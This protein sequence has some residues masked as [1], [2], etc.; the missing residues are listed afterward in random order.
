MHAC[1]VHASSQH[2]SCQRPLPAPFALTGMLGCIICA[3]AATACCFATC[4]PGLIKNIQASAVRPV[5]PGRTLSNEPQRSAAATATTF[6]QSST[7]A[8]GPPSFVGSADTHDSERCHDDHGDEDGDANGVIHCCDA[9]LYAHIDQLTDQGRVRVLR[10]PEAVIR[11]GVEMGNC[12]ADIPD[13]AKDFGSLYAKAEDAHGAVLAVGEFRRGKWV[14]I[15][16]NPNRPGRRNRACGRGKAVLS[17][18]EVLKLFQEYEPRL[19]EFE[20]RVNSM[21]PS[22]EDSNGLL[23]DMVVATR[24]GR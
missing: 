17:N 16:H 21:R 14:H 23:T 24:R 20:Q 8:L 9:W 5:A 15:A 1:I 13:V 2:V 4:P 11:C 7:S 10:S 18:I 12:L 6:W 19:Q 22:V 3:G